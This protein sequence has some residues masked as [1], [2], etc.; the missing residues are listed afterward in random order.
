MDSNDGLTAD[1][2]FVTANAAIVK[3][4]E[5]GAGEGDIVTLNIAGNVKWGGKIDGN[6]EY[7]TEY[8]FKLYVVSE[9]GTAIIGDGVLNA[10]MGGATVFDNVKVSTLYACVFF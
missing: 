2:A 7:V 3:A 5:A 9:D 4:I 10:M 1:T 8:D 6:Y